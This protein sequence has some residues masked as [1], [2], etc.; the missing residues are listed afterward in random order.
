[1]KSLPALLLGCLTLSLAN[2]IVVTYPKDTPP[3]VLE[4]AMKSVIS[5]G[6]HITHKFEIIN[7]FSADAPES[8]VQKISVQSAKYN[9]TIEKDLTVSIQ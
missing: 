1:M 4:D 9:P 6:G 7:G 2:P 8:A 5:A 3:S